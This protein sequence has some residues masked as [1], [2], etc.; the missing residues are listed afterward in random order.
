LEE[1][2]LRYTKNG[3]GFL[4]CHKVGGNDGVKNINTKKQ[5]K[6]KKESDAKKFKEDLDMD[7]YLDT[8]IQGNSRRETDVDLIAKNNSDNSDS[9]SCDDGQKND[10]E[11]DLTVSKGKEVKPEVKSRF[12]KIK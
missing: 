7:D 5:K 12:Q 6:N 9:F 11:F 2:R 3:E 8:K 10:L 4:E 1:S